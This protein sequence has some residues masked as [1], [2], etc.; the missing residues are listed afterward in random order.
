MQPSVEGPIGIYLFH[1]KAQHVAN[2]SPPLCLS[3]MQ[4][5]LSWAFF[6]QNYGILHHFS[7]IQLGLYS[8]S[9]E[10]P[11]QSVSVIYLAFSLTVR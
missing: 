8:L 9:K 11:I 5:V 1:V 7:Q 4:D 10:Y 3:S 6:S 2:F